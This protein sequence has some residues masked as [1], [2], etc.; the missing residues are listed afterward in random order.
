M[1]PSAPNSA[2]G[3]SAWGA[4]LGLVLLAAVGAGIWY[5]TRPEPVAVLLQEVGRGLVEASVANTRAGTL[6]ACQRAKMA[7]P[8]GGQVARIG[9]VEGDR[10]RAGQLLLSLW[11]EDRKA[12]LS[13]AES[14]ATAAQARIEEACALAQVARREAS[15]LLRL[16]Q[17][18]LVSEEQLD[19]AQTDAQAR[20][21][22]CRAARANEQVS[23]ARV[24]VAQAELERTILR[25]PF[26]GIVA[27]VNAKLGEFVTPSPPG[28]PTLPAIDLIATQC[29]YVSAPIDEVDAPAIRPGQPVRIT[30]DAFGERSFEGR[31]RRIA[32]YVLELEKQARTV[33]VEATFADGVDTD[34]LLP[35]YSADIEVILDSRPNVLRVPTEA[36]L[37]GYHVLVYRPDSGRLEERSFKPGLANWRYTEVLSGIEA[38]ERIVVSVEREGVAPGARVVP[39]TSAAARPRR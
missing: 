27:E 5:A 32:P 18:G 16:K 17:S 9:V 6:E 26:A 14:E 11:N 13:L 23:E 15:R 25:A 10:V 21:A 28:I 7:P 33:E 34:Q 20:E 36:V 30:L 39:E 1:A 12:Q 19:R 31:V 2:G 29:I 3:R 24:A 4:L 38:G 8:T 35:G 37:Q 22:A